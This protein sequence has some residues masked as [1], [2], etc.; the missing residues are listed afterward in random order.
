MFMN[1]F[2]EKCAFR[3]GAKHILK[4]L[5]R[6]ALMLIFSNIQHVCKM[7]IKLL[8]NSTSIFSKYM[9]KTTLTDLAGDCAFQ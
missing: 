4:S 2:F 5:H 1:C 8:I 9:L 3:C 6:C 7:V